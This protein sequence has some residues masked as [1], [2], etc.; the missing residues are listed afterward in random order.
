MRLVFKAE[1]HVADT[2]EKTGSGSGL[3]P[4]WLADRLQNIP[5]LTTVS[6]QP[7]VRVRESPLSLQKAASC[8]F[9]S[10]DSEL[11]CSHSPSSTTS[12]DLSNFLERSSVS[13][14]LAIMGSLNNL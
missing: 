7:P 13:Q 11:P 4:C 2:G 6:L 8:C 10:V 5:P 9:L 1:S 12:L 3:L 14:N